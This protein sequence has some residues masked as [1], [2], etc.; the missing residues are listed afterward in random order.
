M[1]NDLR[2]FLVFFLLYVHTA[3]IHAQGIYQFWGIT[4]YGGND[5]Q[6]VLFSSRFD[7]TAVKVRDAF[8]IQ[9]PG[10]S[11]KGQ[12]PVV[13]N[14]KLYGMMPESGPFGSGILYEYDPVS[15]SYTK[16]ANLYD[17]GPGIKE[18]VGKLVAFNNIL[19]GIA[20][21]ASLNNSGV[22]FSFNPAT[23]TVAVEYEF[24]DLNGNNPQAGLMLYNNKLYGTTGGGGV[25]QNGVLYSFD[26]ATGT[27]AKLAEF[28][29]NVGRYCFSRLVLYNSRLY[30]TTTYGGV[31]NDGTIFEFN[32]ANNQLVKEADFN[33]I[34]ASGAYG[35]VTVWNGKLYGGTVNGGAG[36]KGMLY[37]YDPVGNSLLKKI[38]LSD[39][40]GVEIYGSLTLYNNKFYGLTRVGGSSQQGVLFE[41]DPA[42]NSYAKKV[43]LSSSF[44]EYPYGGLAVH[45][46]RLY[47]LTYSGGA[48]DQGVLFEYNPAI[49]GYAKKLEFGQSNG[50][51]P[52]GRLTYFNG[53][54]YGTT[55]SGGDYNE[56]VIFSYDLA[57]HSYSIRHHMT[58]TSGT[59]LDQGGMLL[60]NNKLYGVTY[61][62]GN[63]FGVLYEFDPLSDNYTVKHVFSET[64]GRAPMGV[65]VL[66]NNKLYGTTR[67]GGAAGVGVL[68]EFDPAL[69]S[70]SVKV[71]FS[72]A[73]GKYP[74]AS[75]TPYNALLYGTAS[76]GGT[77]DGGTLFEYNP[78]INGFAVRYNFLQADGY[79]PSSAMLVHNNIL[80]GTT[81]L[82]GIE[83]ASGTI[84]A[85]NPANLMYVK[86]HDL[87]LPGEQQ[88]RA[89]LIFHN[90]KF[91][92][93]ANVGGA[94]RF[95]G[96][97]YEYDFAH[98]IFVNKTDFVLTNGRL[99]RH[100]RLTVLP[101]LVAPG[102][103]G[104]C[105]SGGS[106]FVDMN[107]NN[108]W[109]PFTDEEGNAVAEI[110]ANGNLLGNVR[111]D[112][113]THN[114]PTRQ[115]AQGRYY[116]NRNITITVSNQPV[117]PVSVRLYIRKTEFDALKNT[118]GSGIVNVS[119]INVFKNDDACSGVIGDEAASLVSSVTTWGL[120]YVFTTEV[121]SFSS[122]Y[123]ASAAY[124][125][126]PVKLEYFTGEVKP[127]GNLLNWKASC[128][129]DVHFYVERSKDGI[130]FEE[131]GVV[132]ASQGDCAWPFAY[133]DQQPLPGKQYYRLRMKEANG[134]TTYSN[135]ILL[136]RGEGGGLKLGL[137]PNPV[138]G[139]EGIFLIH[140]P[141]NR[142]MQLV[143]YDNN[144]RQVLRLPVQVQQGVQN[145]SVDISRLPAGLYHA[146]LQD[147]GKSVSL[148]FVKK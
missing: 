125:T 72:V 36:G 59:T 129:D 87:Q 26:P 103:P 78:A 16:K 76:S 24:E 121:N 15:A 27:Y 31:N 11:N 2:F 39:V 133:M 112:F 70:Y 82:G 100:T 147:G 118:A 75:L 117:A 105:H 74:I 52:N 90:N 56:G 10:K 61:G 46:S 64:D 109:I 148:K 124:G 80:W 83:D 40:N 14:G 104:S 126:L 19:Y 89:D 4:D 66:H 77:N 135:I 146:V 140:S 38:D 122:F 143:I 65:P 136:D 115:D 32:P 142:K 81:D 144:G 12:D 5:D 73:F 51:R 141:V 34:G 85:F 13:Y 107:N 111:V 42:L 50:Y 44:G 28:D 110:K 145:K 101:A 47:G 63:G 88:S 55:S 21:E 53:K 49:N 137:A 91:Y 23:G 113:Y 139:D 20:A 68:Y 43:N 138:V 33:A 37:E 79:Q 99:P 97:L 67:Y 102:L 69:N 95:G 25:N 92:G 1:K 131:L 123:F 57:T 119:D 120:D 96:T 93:L 134:E 41:Y 71:H 35:G 132:T 54:L 116:L 29:N 30:G 114:G 6:G 127:G 106:A 48:Y 86:K 45:N 108:E 130:Q 94:M 17:L 8:S 3:G 128:T 98:D 60:Y 18:P 62:G 22:L 7:G 58:G 84:Y 9:L